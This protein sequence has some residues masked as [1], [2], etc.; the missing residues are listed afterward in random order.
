MIMKLLIM[1]L[2]STSYALLNLRQLVN[3]VTKK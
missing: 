2:K 1:R 3:K